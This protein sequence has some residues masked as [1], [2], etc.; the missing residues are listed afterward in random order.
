MVSVSS[1]TLKYGSDLPDYWRMAT[2]MAVM[3]TPT[4]QVE[5]CALRKELR[6]AA[7]VAG[8]GFVGGYPDGMLHDGHNSLSGARTGAQ[9][10]ST[11]LARISRSTA[12]PQ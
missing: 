2:L 6:T 3:S 7:A 4:T 10:V 8:M 11:L 12:R 1:F 5:D 9:S